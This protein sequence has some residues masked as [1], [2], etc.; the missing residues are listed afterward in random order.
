MAR[1]LFLTEQ[2]PYPL[3]SGSRIRN[4]YVLRRLAACHKVTL[5]SFVRNDDHPE[6]L[7]HLE[8]FLDDV[9]TV[10]MSRSWPRN[11]C[12]ALV[13]LTTGRPV[14]IAR[15]TIRAMQRRVEALLALR[16]DAVHAD[17]ITMAQYGLLGQGA[18]VKRLLDQHDV[19]FLL[20]ERLAQ[21]QRSR[22]M[23]QLL[24]REAKAFARYEV[25]VCRRFDHV[26]FVTPQDRQALSARLADLL[27]PDRSSVIP[28]CVDAGVVRPVSPVP[29]PFRVTYLG[30]MYWPP[31]VEGFLWFWENVWPQVRARVPEARL[32]CI[33]KNP[34]E[35]IR[36]LDR[37][38]GVDVLGYVEDLAP[39]LAETG[40][41]AVPLHAAGGMRVKILDAW[42]WGLPVVSTT[43]GAEGIDIE[44][45]Q[46]ILIA[47][48]PAAFAATVVQVLTDQDVSNDLRTAGRRWVEKR[49][50]WRR[51][52]GA[53]DDIY[54]RLLGGTSLY[55][56]HLLACGGEEN[57]TA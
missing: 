31:N 40:V 9:Q 17:Q 14:I 27:L 20:I 50:H 32:T 44:Q 18:G 25:A 4:Y 51:V 47:D 33:G 23:R 39:Y 56:S 22:L 42:C 52:Y 16:F 48:S 37:Q 11:L 3:I 28:I 29:A 26:T 8:T 7:A 35:R 46:N 19:P 38:S 55:G 10:P 36:A 13:S 21:S 30:T 2:L 1:I 43:I 12:A 45:G 53:W 54:D 15:E 5:L 6:D 49:Y 41:F 34:P 57:G 24:L